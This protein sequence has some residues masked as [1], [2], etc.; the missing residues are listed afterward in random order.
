MA[1]FT[2]RATLSYN[3]ITTTSNIVTGEIVGAL[4]VTK[5]ALV[6]KYSEGDTV[7]YV[8]TLINN[9]A[10]E[11]QDVT[12]TDDLGAY[13]FNSMTLVPLTYQEESIAY[14]VN[15]VPQADP[16]ITAGD[17]LVI[18]GINIPADGNAVIVY[19]ARLNGFAPLETGSTVTNTVT[20]NGANASAEETITAAGEADLEITKSLSPETV[21]EN[22]ELTYTFVISNMGAEAADEDDQVVLSDTFDPILSNIVVTLEGETLTEGTDYTYDETTGEFNTVAGVIT[23]PAA[24]FAQDETTGEWL[25]TPCAVTMTITGTV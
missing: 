10:S 4:T 19:S 2:N 3:G 18:S 1:A 17:S 12:L 16:Q 7:T 15:G 6:D 22:C 25:V 11:L 8:I 24:A 13:E 9:G 14:F 21:A 5:T 23:V 20:V